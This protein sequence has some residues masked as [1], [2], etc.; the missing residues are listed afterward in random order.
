MSGTGVILQLH[1]KTCRT[2]QAADCRRAAGKDAAFFR[3]SI[4][5]VKRDVE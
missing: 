4:L 2:A 1:I 5:S 3:K